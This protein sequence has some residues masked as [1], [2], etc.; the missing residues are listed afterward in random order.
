MDVSPSVAIVV[1]RRPD[2]GRR[3]VLWSFCRPRWEQFGYPIVEGEHLSGPFN[4]SAAINT[5]VA[6][7]D[8][9]VVLVVDGDV[10]IDPAQVVAAVDLAARTGKLVPAYTDYVALTEAF[11]ERV[12][13]GFDGN[14]RPGREFS[15]AN[16]VS[17]VLAVPRSLFDRVGGFDERFTG[18][19]WDDVAFHAACKAAAGVERV[20]G[21][22]WHLWHPPAAENDENGV[23]YRNTPAY[24]A[25]AALADR[26]CTDNPDVIAAE[27]RAAD[28]VVAVI[29][30]TGTRDTLERTVESF[31]AQVSGPIGRKMIVVDGKAQPSFD[32]WETVNVRAGGYGA[33][34]AA[35]IR[36]AVGSGQPW[37]F[38]SED[39]FL[40][41]RPADL[42]ELQAE[43]DDHPDLVQ[44]SLL[45]QAWYRH[46][47]DAGGVVEA[48]PDAFE[49]RGRHLR[50]RAYWTMN[51]HL[52][53]RLF[54]AGHPWPKGKW[55]EAQF[56]ERV[57]AES[58][59][60][61]GVW[62]DGSPWVTHIGE[63][64]AGRGY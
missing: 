13:G 62:G 30:T 17:S 5:A 35:G 33:A 7:T 10:V 59:T 39:D 44:M 22:V 50:H 64:K 19:G 38:W 11:T 25:G 1:P 24:L 14:W 3:D 37:V 48:D 27:S 51:P 60:H 20:K 23:S 41:D 52:T 40:F 53:R 55:S 6:E 54:L 46:E 26:Y 57:F 61:A 42:G 56:A 21:T 16:H 15:M 43:M 34:V 58:H 32:G 28:Q 8:S 63:V 45:R 12:L 9:D 49:C 18:W 36:V 31:D 29:L 2:G 47:L 4:R